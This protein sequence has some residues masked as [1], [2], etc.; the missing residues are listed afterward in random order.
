M[1]EMFPTIVG[2]A[3]SL[4][5]IVSGILLIP[6]HLYF[7]LNKDGQRFDGWYRLVWLGLTLK[8][9]KIYPKQSPE[10]MD[11]REE[12]PIEK[13][14]NGLKRPK[15]EINVPDQKAFIDA[16]PAIIH[17][18]KNVIGFFE[19]DILS[20]KICFGL[21]DPVDTAMTS[22]YLWA[23]VSAF[24]LYRSNVQIEPYFDGERLKGSLMAKLR[25]RLIWIF[26]AIFQAIKNE[27]LRKLIGNMA[28][29]K[30]NGE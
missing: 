15:Y 28:E 24:G 2:L 16:F 25:T 18:F 5:L 27:K 3:I 9:G 17:L 22:G 8:K 6:F 26:L 10:L 11:K 20:C 12:K 1:I 14:P 13:V 19:L 29:V 21:H 4:T 7:S 30:G 23:I